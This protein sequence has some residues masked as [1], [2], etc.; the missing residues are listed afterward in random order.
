MGAAMGFLI[1][2]EIVKSSDDID[3]LGYQL[4]VM[5]YGGAA[6]TTVLLILVLIC[7]YHTQNVMC[8]G[9]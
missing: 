5:M 4:S 9:A 3:K 7:A 6:V 2:P 1:P 8:G